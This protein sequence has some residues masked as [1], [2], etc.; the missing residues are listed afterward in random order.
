MIKVKKFLSIICDILMPICVVFIILCATLFVRG[1][2]LHHV[3]YIDIQD[4]SV[5]IDYG[6]LS[7]KQIDVFDK[8]IDAVENKQSVVC[9][10]TLSSKEKHQIFTQ[11]G[12]YYGS[13]DDM[14]DAIYWTSNKATLNI[15]LLEELYNNKLIIDARIDEA[16]STLK[17]GS[18][19]YKLWQISNYISKRITYDNEYR[20]T[21]NALNGRGVCHEYA[22]LF[23]KMA[24]RIGIKTYVC[25]GYAGEYHAWNMVD[26]DGEFLFYDVTWFDD[27]TRNFLYIH[28]KSSWDRTFQLNNVWSMDLEDNNK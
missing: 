9:I 10:P 3:K 14:W 25:Y 7:Q 5:S 11:L 17:E 16:V 18:D 22:I 19:K 2:I 26:I 15:E 13:V 23:Y 6:V 1:A 27:G 8:I 12:L 20:G 21:I 4:Y 28:R 24:T